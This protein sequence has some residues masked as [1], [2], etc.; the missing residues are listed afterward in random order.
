MG[1]EPTETRELPLRLSKASLSTN[2][3]TFPSCTVPTVPKVP[4]DGLPPLGAG[5]FRSY[6]WYGRGGSD[7]TDPKVPTAGA[8]GTPVGIVRVLA[9]VKL[10]SIKSSF[11]SFKDKTYSKQN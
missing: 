9:S 11:S 5:A 3:A 4:T 7:P 10:R 1:F 8:Y 2:S 6:L